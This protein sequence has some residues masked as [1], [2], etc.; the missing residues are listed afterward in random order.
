MKIRFDSDYTEGCHP[1]ILEALTAANAQQFPGYGTDAVCAR[2]AALI[3]AI[4][5]L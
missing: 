1:K 3:G 5:S 2:A 4:R